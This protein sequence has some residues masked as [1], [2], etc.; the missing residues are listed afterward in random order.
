MQV[1]VEL[2]PRFKGIATHG[3][4]INKER[5]LLNFCPD[6]RGLR[7]AE[8]GSGTCPPRR[9]NFC[10]D[11]RGLRQSSKRPFYRLNHV[12]LLPR[13]K[14]IATTVAFQ[15]QLFVF[16]ELLP[17]FKGIATGS[18]GGPGDQPTVELLPRFKGIATQHTRAES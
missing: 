13:F 7:L 3:R 17:R 2:L 6:S 12:E 4:R 8:A 5:G 14:G 1:P 11:S 10:P 9:L 15:Q 18:R 16:V